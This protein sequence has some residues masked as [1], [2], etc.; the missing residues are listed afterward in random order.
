M[1]IGSGRPCEP[2]QAGDISEGAVELL[3]QICLRERKHRTSD[4]CDDQSFL[5]CHVC[6]AALCFDSSRFLCPMEIV[7]VEDYKQSNDAAYSLTKV[8]ETGGAYAEAIDV[9]EADKAGSAWT[10]C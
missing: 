9:L 7:H 8:S 5:R 6:V 3:A 2:E 10:C 4:F 1:D